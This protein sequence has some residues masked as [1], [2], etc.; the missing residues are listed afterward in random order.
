MERDTNTSDL[1]SDAAVQLFD[2]LQ[3]LPT[4]PGTRAILCN[5]TPRFP[6]TARGKTLAAIYTAFAKR[7]DARMSASAPADRLQNTLPCLQASPGGGKSFLLDELAALKKTDLEL[8]ESTEMKE[9]L[10]HSVAISITFNS[11][12]MVVPAV[13]KDMDPVVTRV[14]WAYFFDPKHQNVSTAPQPSAKDPQVAKALSTIGKQLNEDPYFNVV[15]STLDSGPMLVERTRSG[16]PIT[17]IPLPPLTLKDSLLLFKSILDEEKEPRAK[18]NIALAIS[19]CGGH[20]RSLE[21]LWLVLRD[22]PNLPYLSFPELI[23]PVIYHMLLAS[24]PKQALQIA[25]LGIPL[26]LDTPIESG[27]HSTS[28]CTIRSEIASGLYLNAL[29]SAGDTVTIIPR[30]SPLRLRQ[31]AQFG[32]RDDLNKCLASMLATETNFSGLTFEHFHAWWEVLRRLLL[33]NSSSL[34]GAEASHKDQPVQLGQL[35]NIDS[36][37]EFL[38]QKKKGVIL[39]RNHFPCTTASAVYAADGTELSLQDMASYVLMP[40]AGNPGSDITLI[41]KKPDNRGYIVINIECRY[42]HPTS[43][44]QLTTSELERKWE[45]MQQ[46]FKPLFVRSHRPKPKELKNMQLK[47]E[48]VYLVVCA[49]RQSAV[50]VPDSLPQL[51]VLGREKLQELY[52]P[53]LAIRPQFLSG[54]EWESLMS[55]VAPTERGQDEKYSEAE[56]KPKRLWELQK[57]LKA[58][59]FRTSRRKKDEC[60][61][62]IIQ[63]CNKRKQPLSPVESEEEREEE[64]K[65]EEKEKAKKAKDI[66]GKGKVSHH[67]KQKK[68]K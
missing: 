25:L 3:T 6:C 33:I 39:L 48:D 30:L 19:E 68:S 42:S 63:N 27:P 7:L 8:C 41:E 34:L 46:Q 5:N 23:S 55:A 29:E 43:G 12:S 61:H 21:S 37:V 59:G 9:I 2:F 20:P 11:D 57:I 58:N 38:L 60:I 40:A 65:E 32:P 18:A 4:K 47:P 49:F 54:P 1:F 13:E 22:A 28:S 36:K 31:Y 15:V 52:S 45:L 16:R 66:K 10:L 50:V 51:L 62:F 67:K 64:E 17:W 14:L 53:S 35:Y 26:P 44:T 56:Q 24:I